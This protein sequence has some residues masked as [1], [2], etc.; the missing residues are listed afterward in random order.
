MKLSLQRRMPELQLSR[1]KLEAFVRASGLQVPSAQKVILTFVISHYVHSHTPDCVK[2]VLASIFS[3]M[4]AVLLRPV[5][6]AKIMWWARQNTIT[7]P[8]ATA[9]AEG[10][11]R[12][13]RNLYYKNAAQE[14]SRCV[15]K[16]SMMGDDGKFH[17]LYEHIKIAR[18]ESALPN[19]EIIDGPMPSC[20]F[21]C[22]VMQD[23]RFH[24]RA[25]GFRFGN[26]AIVAQHFTE[27]HEWDSVALYGPK[28][29]RI[30]EISSVKNQSTY[31][32][33]P[34]YE[35]GT[36][37]DIAAILL[38]EDAWCSLGVSAAKP[39]SFTKRAKGRVR[40]HYWC[41][42]NKSPKVSLGSLVTPWEQEKK[43]GVVPHSA[44]TL[45]GLSGC[46]VWM[47]VNNVDKICAYH[48]CGQYAEHR[49]VNYGA[50]CP[51]MWHFFQ[52]LGL[53]PGHGEKPVE[54]TES[55]E[56]QYDRWS[57]PSGGDYE[58]E[59]HDWNQAAED[60]NEF[61]EDVKH[62]DV[63]TAKRNDKS[64]KK[65]AQAKK[66]MTPYVEIDPDNSTPIDMH[67]RLCAEIAKLKAELSATRGQLDACD[68]Y[69]APQP[70]PQK[71]VFNLPTGPNKPIES[72]QTPPGL[73]PDVAKETT[74]RLECI[75]PPPLE[76]ER[77]GRFAPPKTAKPRHNGS[78]AKKGSV[79]DFLTE[80]DPAK[81]N[82]E[83]WSP[84]E[85]FNSEEFAKFR[86]YV[87]SAEFAKF[88]E[89]RVLAV[90]KEGQTMA[91]V[92]G[93]FQGAS[94]GPSQKRKEIQKKHID[95]CAKHGLT[96]EKFVVPGGSVDEIE[97]SLIAQLR[98]AKCL[99]AP[100]TQKERDESMLRM[101]KRCPITACAHFLDSR[102]GVSK[103]VDTLDGSKS[104]GWSALYLRGQKSVW[105]TESGK[106]ELSYLTR[107]RIILRLLW[108]RKAMHDM[109]PLEMVE[110]GLK[111]PLWAHIKTEPHPPHK[112]NEK[113]W[114]IIWASSVLDAMCTA[115]TSRHQDKKDIELYK[116]GVGGK[117]TYHTLGMGHH[118]EGIVE[119]GKVLD[120]IMAQG[121]IQ[122]EDAKAW[123]M[124]VQ[125]SWVYAD[126]QRRCLAYQGPCHEIFC[127]LQWCEAAAN[128][129][130]CLCYGTKVIEILKAGITGS[131][132]LTT[133]GQNSFM[134]AWLADLCGAKDMAANGDDLIAVGISKAKIEEAG[135]V[136]KG[137]AE[138]TSKDGPVEF[139]SHQYTKVNGAWTARFLN[140]DK[141]L[142]RLML[143][144]KK[145]T[146]EA[147]CGCLFALRNS[148]EQTAQFKAIC[149]SCEW[150]I[151]G[152]TPIQTDLVD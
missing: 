19:E 100:F 137:L 60:A 117:P 2:S 97:E 29:K 126:A 149:Q 36:G 38:P 10:Y 44:T 74:V 152:C 125:R 119:F 62:G 71:E 26:Y 58:D 105:Q 131:G 141:M 115:M 67:T 113:R 20:M 77:A 79:N 56:S 147:L 42:T 132:V 57:E 54:S 144:D 142:A 99:S 50:S 111:D 150:P 143:G 120:R 128:S 31:H 25:H 9:T 73:E 78:G 98:T 122:D 64:L 61:S 23:G 49:I 104:A 14:V 85:V 16:H 51:D 88:E 27:Q 146:V 86:R 112:A 7:A 33:N 66:S 83:G 109:T 3:Q 43:D 140:L 129:A 118:D 123:D 124:S 37:T 106:Q 75:P 17:P 47:S 24:E 89:A 90:N 87:K 121:Y 46:P 21:V 82:F 72:V 91:Q 30:L 134:R 69:L 18:T 11:F 63:T 48:V 12:A 28:V 148:E 13:G 145:P 133:S 139:T 32:P 45:P 81:W 136:S 130:H 40:V 80:R 59:M 94:S 55:T 116:G 93:T 41:T 92:V 135:Y 107:C 8:M 151:E 138:C 53:V 39:T 76:D 110:H 68:T 5:Q 114:R 101:H 52:H 127:E 102:V 6:D 15:L 35:S 1:A 103:V 96:M 108:G 22:G 70:Q 95:I 84:T 34:Q 4:L 65:A